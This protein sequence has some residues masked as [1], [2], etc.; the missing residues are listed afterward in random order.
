MNL[1]T[2]LKN[3]EPQN[4]ISFF[5]CI[6]HYSQSASVLTI[7]EDDNDHGEGEKSPL[8]AIRVNLG[9]GGGQREE[10]YHHCQ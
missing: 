5:L 9:E 8:P 7:N 10:D 4:Y 1:E 3:Y 2:C 6:L